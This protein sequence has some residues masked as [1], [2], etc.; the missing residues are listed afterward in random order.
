MCLAVVMV[1]L[2]A[3]HPKQQ[4][5]PPKDYGVA[6]NHVRARISLKP[7]PSNWIMTRESERYNKSKV[8][9]FTNPNIDSTLNEPKAYYLGKMLG[10]KNDILMY[11]EDDYAI[12]RFPSPDDCRLHAALSYIYYYY[13]TPYEDQGGYYVYLINRY[14]NNLD[15]PQGLFDM[16]DGRT[17]RDSKG[18]LMEMTRAEADSILL[19]VWGMNYFS[20]FVMPSSV[21]FI[22]PSST[23]YSAPS[24]GGKKTGLNHTGIDVNHRGELLT[25]YEEGGVHR[26]RYPYPLTNYLD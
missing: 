7:I 3:C 5:A 23:I 13:P 18:R 25:P 14:H 4:P 17:R 1:L 6:Y 9:M 24:G 20:G 19:A 10:V 12:L 16:E 11:E 15:H 26:K 22:M 8:V 2:A 21:A